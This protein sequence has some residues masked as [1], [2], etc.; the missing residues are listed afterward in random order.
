MI[1]TFV[2]LSVLLPAPF[3][4]CHALTA[5][6]IYGRDIAAAMPALTGLPP[7]LAVGYAPAPGMERVFRPAELRQLARAQHLMAPAVMDN[8]CFGW[9]LAVIPPAQMQQSMEKTLTGRNPQVEI[10]EQS[11]APAPPGELVFPL[12][13]LSAVSDKPAIW[14]GYVL[15]AGNRRFSTWAQVRV[16][17]REAHLVT[18]TALPTGET[19]TLAELR[20]ELYEGAPLRQQALFDP[21]QMAGMVTRWNIPAGAVLVA[22]MFEVRKDVERGD[23]VTVLVV[24]G[25]A[26]IETQGIAGQA[27]RRGDVIVVRN[28]KTG[29]LYRARVQEKGTVLVVAGGPAGL[30]GEEKKL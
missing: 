17:I 22:E 25:A 27:G 6:R 4:S 7:D 18:T 3:A 1:F 14:K 11:L 20:T 24:N 28:P 13:G 29:S 26:H 23:L 21:S 8:I 19:V 5:E 16:T 10:V 15:Y 30:V 12:A 2:F 9:P